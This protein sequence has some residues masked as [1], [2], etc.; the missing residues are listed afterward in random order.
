ML[1]QVMNFVSG[2]D[3]GWPGAGSPSSYTWLPQANREYQ[4]CFKCHS[5]YTT[6]PT[7]SPDGWSGTS[8]VANGLRKLT[9]NAATQIQDS[10]DLAQE[11]NPNNASFHP[12]SAQGRNQSIPNASFVNGWSQTSLVYCSDCHNNPNS[13]S[14]GVGPH[15]SPLLHILK[16]SA[17]YTTVDGRPPVSGELCFACHSYATY[18]TNEST[19]ATNFRKGGDNLHRKHASEDTTCYACHDTHGSEQLHLINFDVSAMTILD[20]RDTHA[21]TRP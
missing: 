11:F 18:V 20:G 3:P 2:V 10:R 6:L 8:L 13:A 21:S 4:V 14:Q 9:N 7:Y 1:Q 5:S 15:G 16:G 17:N 12:V 19:T